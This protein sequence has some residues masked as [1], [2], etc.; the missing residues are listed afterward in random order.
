MQPDHECI[1]EVVRSVLEQAA[2]YDAGPSADALSAHRDLYHAEI[3][4]RG[5][6]R[7]GVSLDVAPDLARLLASAMTR[8]PQD[9]VDEALICDAVG[10]LANMIAGNLRPLL[11]G[12]EATALPAVSRRAEAAGGGP[13]LV[14]RSFLRDGRRI[15][16]RLLPDSSVAGGR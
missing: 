15:E 4:F 13:F 3:R 7:G 14:G 9:D 1:E 10:E 5:A 2:G 8:V 12:A 6:W 11:K 16:V